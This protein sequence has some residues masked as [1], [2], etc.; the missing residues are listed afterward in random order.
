VRPE[1]RSDADYLHLLGS[2]DALHKE[3]QDWL[4]SLDPRLVAELTHEE[5]GSTIQHEQ[6][7]FNVPRMAS[8][9]ARP[10]SCD[11]KPQLPAKSPRR[12]SS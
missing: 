3:K 11:C 5:Q 10:T 4:K 12:Q 6:Q 2:A 9:Q 1:C 7:N 8:L